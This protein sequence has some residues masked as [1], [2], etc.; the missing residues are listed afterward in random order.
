VSEAN[1]EA[2]SKEREM[3][4]EPVCWLGIAG[5]VG[6]AAALCGIFSKSCKGSCDCN[7]KNEQPQ[8]QQSGKPAAG[9]DEK[10]EK[11]INDLIK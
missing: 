7:T 5:V 10:K 1:D 9:I 2:I 8:A 3:K 6:I 11:A 4:M